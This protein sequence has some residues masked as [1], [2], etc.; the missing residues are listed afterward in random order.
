MF[1]G[2]LW[3]LLTDNSGVTGVEPVQMPWLGLKWKTKVPVLIS[4]GSASIL[5]AHPCLTVNYHDGKLRKQYAWLTHQ[6][7]SISVFQG[8]I[9][10]HKINFSRN[11]W[12]VPWRSRY[13]SGTC[14]KGSGWKNSLLCKIHWPCHTL[15]KWLG[16]AFLWF[17]LLICIFIPF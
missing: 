5:H 17:T 13:Q 3:F 7:I 6:T 12:I 2:N 15:T 4:C 8:L 11:W 10:A 16:M 9:L 14:F 1:V